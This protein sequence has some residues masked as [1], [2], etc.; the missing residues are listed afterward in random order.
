M[1]LRLQPDLPS[2]F[3]TCPPSICSLPAGVLL[4]SGVGREPESP[5]V[6]L[7][8]GAIQPLLLSALLQDQRPTGRRR[9]TPS[10]DLHVCNRGESWRRT[11]I[12]LI[13]HYRCFF[14]CIVQLLIS[15]M[16]LFNE[17][18]MEGFINRS[19]VI[20]SSQKGKRQVK[21]F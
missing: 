17:L 4:F 9:G 18:P 6:C 10:P 14:Y 7:L 12:T 21:R 19:L 1:S 5:A 11:V 15:F 16:S 13:T 3:S 8:S 20:I 2:W